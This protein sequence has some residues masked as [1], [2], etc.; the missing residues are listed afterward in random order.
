MTMR[1]FIDKET[2]EII[3]V[4]SYRTPEQQDAYR[5]IQQA[6]QRAN[7][8]DNAFIF[9]EMDGVK[10]VELTN[11]E[12]KQLGW[13]LV[14]QTYI[15][16]NNMLRAKDAKLPMKP[17]ELRKALKITDNRTFKKL[18]AEFEE[19]GLI[20]HKEVEL[21]GKTYKAIFVNDKYCFKKGLQGDN[22]NRKTSNAVKVFI[23]T[24]QDVYEQKK[25]KAGD[26]GI[27]Y[28]A[29]QY[30]HYNSN[31][32]AQNPSE[33]DEAFVEPMNMDEFADAV[34]ISRQGIYKKLIALTYPCVYK[35]E[36]MEFKVFA[37]VSVGKQTFLKLNP[38]VAWRKAG[39]PPVEAYIEFIMEYSKRTK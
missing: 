19:L 37:R 8:S 26:V 2:G 14:M 21:Y 11:L 22:K 33:M 15:D 17:V 12:N 24:L 34:G 27:I 5:K 32:L 30:L 23:D 4:A 36:E 16:Y 6:E 38:F 39:E 3:E 35:G 29:I 9:T 25:V 31:V 13:F 10:F 18:M 20:Y 1:Q 28:K 7:K